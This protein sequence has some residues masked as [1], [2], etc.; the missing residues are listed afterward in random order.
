MKKVNFTLIELLVVIAIIAILA[1]ILLPALN[2]AR[3]RGKTISCVSH[4]KQIGLASSMYSTSYNDYIVPTYFKGTGTATQN[5][6]GLLGVSYMPCSW[7]DFKTQLAADSKFA[8]VLQCPSEPE[9]ERS[10]GIGYQMNCYSTYNEDR[11]IRLKQTACR[12]RK[13]NMI[14]DPSHS[15]LFCDG[16]NKGVFGDHYMAEM[17]STSG[18]S[19]YFYYHRHN[20]HINA[21]LADGHV[22]PIQALRSWTWTG[23]GWIWNLN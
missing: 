23:T 9:A 6:V 7:D 22:E 20:L 11:Y 1:S 4:L 5:W 13:I 18:P 16:T 14:K 21:T 15:V 3:E 19:A 2:R 12:P 17:W 8:A 10:A